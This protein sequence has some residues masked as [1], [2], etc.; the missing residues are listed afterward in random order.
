MIGVNGAFQE[1][2]ISERGS[3][4]DETDSREEAQHNTYSRDFQGVE[5]PP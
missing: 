1:E 5:D 3:K 4:G 2:E